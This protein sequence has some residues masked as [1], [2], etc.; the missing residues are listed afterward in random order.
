MTNELNKLDS[1]QKKIRTEFLNANLTN[2][3]HTQTYTT[4][5]K[6][7]KNSIS[8]LVAETIKSVSRDK[9]RGQSIVN[10]LAL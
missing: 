7:R 4:S 3:S 6:M 8:H 2:V 9:L 5:R 10:K 1:E